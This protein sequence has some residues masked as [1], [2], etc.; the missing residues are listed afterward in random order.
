MHFVILGTYVLKSYVNSGKPKSIPRAAGSDLKLLAE[1]TRRS[2][3]SIPS[4]NESYGYEKTPDGS[5]VLQ[6]PLRTGFSGASGD[7][8]GPGDYD[9]PI[10]SSIVRKTPS[11][12]FSKVM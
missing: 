12:L 10:L 11:A 4:K 9:P 3:P 2:M 1:L 7:A 5:L 8:V 6:R